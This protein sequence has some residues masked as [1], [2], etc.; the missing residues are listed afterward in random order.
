M[1]VALALILNERVA[2]RS[3][4]ARLVI[5]HHVY[6]LDR[7][8]LLEFTLQLRLGRLIVLQLHFL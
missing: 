2:T 1:H 5:V 4:L 6:L 3:I 8:E 7:A